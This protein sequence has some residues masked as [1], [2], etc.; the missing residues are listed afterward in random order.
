MGANGL[1][2]HLLNIMDKGAYGAKHKVTEKGE[3]IYGWVTRR[4]NRRIRVA[5]RYG[6]GT[7]HFHIEMPVT[8]NNKHLQLD[9]VIELKLLMK[10]EKT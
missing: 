8:D 1:T 6:K 7:A 5:Y 3:A 2:Y 9:D 10:V 4:T